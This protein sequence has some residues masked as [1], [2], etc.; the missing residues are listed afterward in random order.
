MKLCGS[1][2]A[3]YDLATPP[4]PEPLDPSWPHSQIGRE[5]VRRILDRRDSGT[6]EPWIQAL[7]AVQ[8]SPDPVA[9]RREFAE[10]HLSRLRAR[11]D[12]AGPTKPATEVMVALLVGLAVA[13]RTLGLLES[14][15][16]WV[17]ER[18]GAMIQALVDGTPVGGSPD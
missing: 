4:D 14:D 16:E 1:K 12:E 2:R 18:C 9:A 13:V 6:A 15:R 17:I 8:D 7:M 3:L 10:Y 11:V 5:L